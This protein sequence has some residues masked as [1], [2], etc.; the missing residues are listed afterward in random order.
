METVALTPNQ[1][2]I[3]GDFNIHV[4]VLE[5]RVSV[6]FHDILDIYGLQQHV[7]E[8]THTSG[9]TLDLIISRENDDFVSTLSS[10]IGLPSDHIAVKCLINIK[11]PSPTR[12]RVYGRNLR[13]NDMTQLHADIL[14]SSLMTHP[15]RDVELLSEQYDTVLGEIINNH[16]PLSGRD[17]IL[18]HMPLGTLNRFVKPNEQNIA[19]SEST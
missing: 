19:V 13:N 12:K 14:S 6:A 4:D 18:R 1:L 3:T 2:L 10:H 15:A 17:I 9:H 16:A 11:R 7:T 8:T 5:D